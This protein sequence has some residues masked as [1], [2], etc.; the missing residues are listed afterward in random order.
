MSSLLAYLQADGGFSHLSGGATDSIATEQAALA[1]LS[2]LRLFAGQGG[3]YMLGSAGNT[4]Q[5][6]AS[7]QVAKPESQPT[8]EDASSQAQNPS[9]QAAESAN[10]AAPAASSSAVVVL[11]LSAVAITALLLWRLKFNRKSE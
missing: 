10:S 4:E 9:A 2:Y 3:V 8:A 7:E 11:G 6:E 5:T 1:L